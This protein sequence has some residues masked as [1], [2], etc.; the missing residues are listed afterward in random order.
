MATLLHSAPRFTS[1]DGIK[2]A[3]SAAL[4][5]MLLGAKEEHGEIIF[6]VERERIEDALARVREHD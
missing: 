2:D 5:T 6:G 3:L 4:G 1:N